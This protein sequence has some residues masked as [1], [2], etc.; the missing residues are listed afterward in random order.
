MSLR[1]VRFIIDAPEEFQEPPSLD[2]SAEKPRLLVE[3]CNPDRT[4]AGLRDILAAA[5]RLYDRG[6][7]VRLAFDQLQ[8]GTV[9]QVMTPDG[10]VLMAHAT[11]R[12]YVLKRMKN[13][14]LCEVDA[15]LPRSFA[16]MYLDWRGE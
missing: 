13:G 12:P 8:R 1:N 5:G 15:R 10:L 11:C 3:D 4:V 9:A 14:E 7:P 2:V 6:L 16:V